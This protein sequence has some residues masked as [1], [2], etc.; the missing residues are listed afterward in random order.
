[1][2]KKT[3]FKYKTSGAL[4]FLLCLLLCLAGA[5]VS[6]Y[7]F[8]A[9]LSRSLSKQNEK[10]VATITERTR[11]VQRKF[12][13]R[14]IWDRLGIDS[15]VYDGDTIYTAPL[16]D[17]VL[18]FADG[19]LLALSENT[20]AQVFQNEDGS[21]S[22]DLASGRISVDASAGTSTLTVV[23]GNVALSVSAGARL[24]AE[25]ADTDAQ[26][27]SENAA[28]GGLS[29]AVLEGSASLAD[30]TALTA[31]AA[32]N[33]TDADGTLSVQ[34]A[35]DLLLH[36]SD[37]ESAS[38]VE[39]TFPP[40]GYTVWKPLSASVRI[41]VPEAASLYNAELT[42]AS[43][44][45]F[46]DIVHTSASLSL[47]QLEAGDYWWQ[48]GA[49]SARLLHVVPSFPAPTLLFPANASSFVPPSN[50]ICTFRWKPLSGADYYR[51][52]LY[53]SESGALLADENFIEETSCAL[54]IPE[55]ASGSF[56]WEL[57]AFASET[58]SASRRGGLA[59]TAAFVM[60]AESQPLQTENVQKAPAAP[61]K[62]KAQSTPMLFSFKGML[63]ASALEKI[64][65]GASVVL[66]DHIAV[67]VDLSEATGLYALAS[68][69]FE[70]C[71]RL[72][73]IILPASIT[74]IE[75]GAFRGCTAL[76]EVHYAGSEKAWQ[77]VKVAD[78]QIAHATVVCAKEGD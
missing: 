77:R 54:Q 61:A 44:R 65:I 30:G 17:V 27:S 46:S 40:D 59:A 69:A 48:L 57:T 2:K 76:S 63:S 55:A 28:A 60:S 68:G 78:E 66:S 72:T 51:L 7:L 49:G 24:V 8:Y 67:T 1:M 74:R 43:D 36:A 11:T 56:R 35:P 62:K 53:D 20:M 38:V 42:I 39:P 70:D 75:A 13:G 22:T 34:N 45:S 37:A 14:M 9:S 21:A 64:R 15:P 3:R 16:S 26:A 58:E 10:P 47:P 4:P 6:L 33:V 71:P 5:V 25:T 18:Q 23:S 31:G 50:R 12:S 41:A 52:Q 32:V 19:T 29:V 73:C